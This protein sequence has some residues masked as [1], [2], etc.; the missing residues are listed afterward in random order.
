LISRLAFGVKT[1]FKKIPAFV[2]KTPFKKIPAFQPNYHKYAIVWLTACKPIPEQ[3]ILIIT[4]MH[5]QKS[6][7]IASMRFSPFKDDRDMTQTFFVFLYRIHFPSMSFFCTK[8]KTLLA[9][10][11]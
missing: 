8:N 4:S 11:A 6:I 10:V 5:L 7:L 2:V 1:H 3:S 9:S